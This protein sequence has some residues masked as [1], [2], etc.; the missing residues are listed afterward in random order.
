MAW[1]IK[2]LINNLLIVFVIE[3]PIA[4][5]LGARKINKIATV[6]LV[7]VITN[8]IVVFL[9]LMAV[10]HIGK[11]S[12]AVLIL[13][14]IFAVLVEGFVFSKCKTFEKKNPWLMSLG[15]NAASFLVGEVIEFFV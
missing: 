9:S 4:I 14:E 2:I 5:L 12:T 13:L 15:L 8:P 1:I 11:W 7:N 6:L 3:T 10:L